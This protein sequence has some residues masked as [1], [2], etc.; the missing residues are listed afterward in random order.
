MKQVSLHTSNSPAVRTHQ[1]SRNIVHCVSVD[2]QYSIVRARE[3]SK[4]TYAKYCRESVAAMH[5]KRTCARHIY[6]DLGSMVSMKILKHVGK[7]R[8]L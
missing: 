1:R 7:L 3:R 6:Y 8:L 4:F 2:R 5:S